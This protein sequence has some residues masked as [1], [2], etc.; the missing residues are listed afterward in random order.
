MNYIDGFVRQRVV[1]N[2]RNE[3][4]IARQENPR[5]ERLKFKSVSFLVRFARG[6]H[7]SPSA[8]QPA[9][10]TLPCP[11]PAKWREPNRMAR[12]AIGSTTRRRG[13]FIMLS[14]RLIHCV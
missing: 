4:G 14:D 12:A 9:A 2:C 13:Q 6:Q 8:L 3:K 5:L 11:A 10:E 7:R 1:G